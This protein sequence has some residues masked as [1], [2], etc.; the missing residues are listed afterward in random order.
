MPLQH[1]PR[2]KFSSAVRDLVSRGSLQDRLLR[3]FINF[4]VVGPKQF[5]T[6]ELGRRFTDLMDR[7]TAV[8]PDNPDDGTIRATLLTMDDDQLESVATEIFDI[9]YELITFKK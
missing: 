4:V 9:Y 3:A 6:E 8:K 7:V 1:Y 5:E 2:E